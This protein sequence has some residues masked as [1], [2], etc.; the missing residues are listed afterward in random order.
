[1][2]FTLWPYHCRVTRS[3]PTDRRPGNVPVCSSRQEP[4]AIAAAP[5]AGLTLRWSL[6]EKRP[7]CAGTL[8]SYSA[9]RR[10]AW[11][12]A[13]LLTSWA[14]ALLWASLFSLR[15]EPGE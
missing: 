5:G 12:T 2:T 8:P 3:L 14:P 4:A 9:G 10:G 11:D 7:L 13:G 1:M 15:R 6:I